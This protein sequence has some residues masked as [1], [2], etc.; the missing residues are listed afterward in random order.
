M[1]EIQSLLKLQEMDMECLALETALKE[2]PVQKEIDGSLERLSVLRE[3]L[4]CAGLEL[5]RVHNEQKHEE[6]QIKDI[7]ATVSS[8]SEKLYGGEITN[9]REI[10]NIRCRLDSLEAT[11]SKLEDDVIALMEKAEALES[12]ISEVNLEIKQRET[13]LAELIG[14]RDLETAAI[15]GKLSDTI[16]GRERLRVQISDSLVKKYE[17]LLRDRGGPVVVPI[18][19]KICGGCHVALPSS[20]IILAKP[21]N[22]VVRCENCGRILCWQE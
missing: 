18:R 4:S 12:E 9:P 19:G 10:E 15:S 6:W 14:K 16:E 21:N 11:K 13:E 5:N 17:Q 8:I 20:L 2:L 22:T 1:T 3:R 7:T